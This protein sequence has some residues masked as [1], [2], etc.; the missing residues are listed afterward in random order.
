MND[1][2]SIERMKDFGV[3]GIISDFPD[4]L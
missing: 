4:L 1:L 3:D 2:K